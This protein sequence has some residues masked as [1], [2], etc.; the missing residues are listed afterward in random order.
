[1]AAT[2]RPLENAPEAANGEEGTMMATNW[3]WAIRAAA[4][5]AAL[6]A[7]GCAGLSGG[8]GP[9]PAAPEARA[10]APAPAPSA[11]QPAAGPFSLP[12]LPYDRA[13]LAPHI[14]AETIAYHYGKHHQAYVD[15]LNNLVA[16]TPEAGKKLEEVI[17]TAS[18]ALFNNA[19]QAW[20]HTFYWNSLKPGGGGEPSGELAEAV[21][22]DFGSYARFREEFA[23]AATTLFGSGWAWLVL[24][25]GK[26][27][28]VQT[29]NADLPMR[30]GQ[31]ALLVIDVWEH[32]YYIDY[33]NARVK[34]VDAVLDHLVNWD[35]A[36]ANYAKA[37]KQP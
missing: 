21:K 31:A 36:A 30:H 23:R 13:V 1:M 12:P 17:M 16:G 26:L 4:A 2:R 3:R 35:F 5:G 24:D 15:N 28:V 18:G 20:N 25:G 34:Y 32:A 7:L 11:A 27:R 29:A 6:A 8:R 9:A 37:A 22:R 33:R 19:A 14:S 10:P